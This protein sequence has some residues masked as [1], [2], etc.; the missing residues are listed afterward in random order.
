[1]RFTR[2]RRVVCVAMVTGIGLLGLDVAPALAVGCTYN[3]CNG[4]DPQSMG[5]STGAKNLDQYTDNWGDYIELR[6]S[7]TCGTVWTRMTTTNCQWAKPVLE[8]G[9]IDYYGHY[10]LQGRYSSAQGLCVEGPRQGWSAM[11]SSRRERMRFESD[12]PRGGTKV[13]VTS[14]NDCY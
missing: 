12:Q 5:C 14:C 2:I 11:S 9:Y 4:K 10:T 1:M 6:Y 13:H 3:S 7:S 8:V